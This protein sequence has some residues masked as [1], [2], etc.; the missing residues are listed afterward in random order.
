MHR[1]NALASA[2][3]EASARVMLRISNQGVNPQLPATHYVEGVHF[4]V[5]NPAAVAVAS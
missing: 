5:P 1:A 3:D 4:N 2:T